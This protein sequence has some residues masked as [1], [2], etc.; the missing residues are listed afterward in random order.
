MLSSP[1]LSPFTSTI[2][3]PESRFLAVA[4]AIKRR[5][6][7]SCSN[8]AVVWGSPDSGGGGIGVLEDGVSATG[9]TLDLFGLFW[10]VQLSVVLLL[11]ELVHLGLNECSLLEAYCRPIIVSKFAMLVLAILRIY[12]GTII[13]V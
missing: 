3:L 4:N 9:V 8:F 11:V 5:S 13:S 10:G 12:F 2:G 6:D 7:I 1:F